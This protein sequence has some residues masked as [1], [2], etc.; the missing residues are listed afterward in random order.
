MDDSVEL[1]E[2]EIEDAMAGLD[3]SDWAIIDAMA[4][5]RRMRWHFLYRP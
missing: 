1:L 4:L 5:A 2:K 3:A